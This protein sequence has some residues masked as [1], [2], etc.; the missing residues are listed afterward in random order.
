M[1]RLFRQK[2][3]YDREPSPEL[4][5][6]GAFKGLAKPE[7]NKSKTDPD[8]EYKERYMYE[9]E[10]IEAMYSPASSYTEI[11]NETERQKLVIKHLEL[12][13]KFRVSKQLKAAI[14]VYKEFLD[15]GPIHSIT[16]AVQA[17]EDMLGTI[18]LVAVQMKKAAKD[19]LA[20]G[21]TEEIQR[22]LTIIKTTASMTNDLPQ[23]VKS[24]T[25]QQDEIVKQV[26]KI[27]AQGDNEI[28]EYE[29]GGYASF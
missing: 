27:M 28:S 10:Y 17:L 12:G 5:S 9:L 29:S 24:L 19:S 20:D 2:N 16:E 7:Y 15:K 4:Q 1:L 26:D 18:K 14:T 25:E 23:Q 3:N 13:A 8:G 21:D 11:L 22:I 6:I